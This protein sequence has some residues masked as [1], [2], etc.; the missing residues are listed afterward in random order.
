MFKADG[1]RRDFPIDKTVI[2]IGRK[3]TCDLRIPLGI[4]SREHCQVEVKEDQLLLR[5]LGSS[6]GTYHNSERVQE[7]SLEAGD[8]LVIGPVHF[9]VV[10]NGEPAEIAEPVKTV[11]PEGA[12]DVDKGKSAAPVMAVPADDDEDDYED[13]NLP[14]DTM[15]DLAE[16]FVESTPPKGVEID[17]P[18]DAVAALDDEI[19]DVVDPTVDLDLAEEEDPIAALEALAA[20][21]RE[22]D[23]EDEDDEDVD[24][25][26]AL[27][28]LQQETEEHEEKH[29][30]R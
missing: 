12:E 4:V 14:S 15:D 5:D 1:E 26:D 28:F 8:T 2:T 30:R 7:A 6:N 17:E 22:D 19:E 20:L 18:V 10:V 9:T 25:N 24:I 27:S 21:D 3:H 11:L 23:D 29:G 16:A 13:D